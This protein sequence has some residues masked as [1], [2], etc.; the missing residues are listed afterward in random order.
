M[1]DMNGTGRAIGALMITAVT[2]PFA[3]GTGNIVDAAR[4]NWRTSDIDRHISSGIAP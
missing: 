2:A 1:R 3:F 4:F